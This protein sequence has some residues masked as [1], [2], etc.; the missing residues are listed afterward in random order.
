MVST[1]NASKAKGDRFER[2]AAE[3]L[4]EVAADLLAIPAR[5]KLGA[6]R[7]DDVGDLD[8]FSDVT[9]QVKALRELTTAIRDAAD[10]ALEQSARAGTRWHVGMTP[11]PNARRGSVRWVC[12]AYQWP[13]TPNVLLPS[14]GRTSDAVSYLTNKD[15]LMEVV[16]SQRIACV[17]RHGSE[18]MFVGTLDAW[19]SSLRRA[20]AILERR[21]S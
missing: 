13:S 3:I 5:R 1:M 8:G 2:E 11:I 9:V 16:Q 15:P 18:M 14:F 12:S 4:N 21:A 20:Y 10:S 19:V 6:G 7:K 17:M